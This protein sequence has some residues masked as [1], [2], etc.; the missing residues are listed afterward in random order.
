MTLKTTNCIICGKE[1]KFWHG[2]VVGREK[3]ALGNYIP[4]KV[5][6][7][8]CDEHADNESDDG[9][10]CYGKYDPALHGKCVPFI[11]DKK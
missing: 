6:A 4:V 5:I 1:A 10:G 8:F 2:H 9:Y 3:R 11:F 7:G